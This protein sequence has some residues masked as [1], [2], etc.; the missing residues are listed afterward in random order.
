MRL[1]YLQHVPFENLAMIEGWAIDRGASI[2]RTRLDLGEGLP[3]VDSFDW[4]V[5]MG[6]PMNIYE[7]ALYPWL[8]AEKALIKAAIQ[9]GKKALGVCL[10]AQLIADALG[11]KVYRNSQKEIGWFP[12][13]LNDAGRADPLFGA[14][15]AHFPAF[16]WHGDTFS[17]PDGAVHVAYSDACSN[18]A[19]VYDNRVVA[20]QFH[21]ETTHQ[22]AERLIENCSD[23]LVA[24]PFIQNVSTLRQGTDVHAEQANMLIRG[25]LDR[26]I[27]G[28]HTD[29]ACAE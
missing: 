25:L 22:S 23:E 19:F 1:H 26:M 11:G 7:D 5:V 3:D 18:Q 24:A 13:S 20:V 15:P 4:L 12:V 8:T 2:T 14:L 6:G 21:L 28:S 16:H 10:G 17:I 29:S 27:D 9:A